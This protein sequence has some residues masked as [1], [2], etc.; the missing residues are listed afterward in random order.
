M[1][2]V[3]EASFLSHLRT[4][5]ILAARTSASTDIEIGAIDQVVETTLDFVKNLLEQ[6]VADTTDSSTL[7]PTDL[8]NTLRVRSKRKFAARALIEGFPLSVESAFDPESKFIVEDLRDAESLLIVF[9]VFQ[10]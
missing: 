1:S 9:F 3:E 10:I 4:K 5:V 2:A 6:M 8:L 7:S